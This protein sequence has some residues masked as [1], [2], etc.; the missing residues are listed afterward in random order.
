DSGTDSSKLHQYPLDISW[1]TTTKCFTVGLGND[2]TTA[3]YWQWSTSGSCP[4][5]SGIVDLDRF[6]GT[7]DQLKQLAGY[8]GLAQVSRNDAMTLVNWTNDGHPE[9]FVKDKSGEM[10]HT[11][12]N[13][14]TD[15]WNKMYTLDMNSE[16]GAA[17]GFWSVQGYAELFDP[18]PDGSAQHLWL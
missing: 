4:G 18:A 15:T 8:G 11:Y 16:C 7:I 1:P 3:A 5:V 13:G 9:I 10:F 14:T 12:P 2:F 6:L 17:A